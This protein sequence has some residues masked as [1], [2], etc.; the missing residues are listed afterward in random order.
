MLFYH[1]KLDRQSVQVSRVINWQ[2]LVA[3]FKFEIINGRLESPEIDVRTR[4]P[5]P[6][7][8]AKLDRVGAVL[9]KINPIGGG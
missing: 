2:C 4:Q 9:K 7:I 6:C 1:E 3:L 5:L 8:V